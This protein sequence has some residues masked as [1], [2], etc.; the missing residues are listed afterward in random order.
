MKHK[1][2][3][4]LPAIYIPVAA[5]LLITAF[6]LYKDINLGYTVLLIAS[7]AVIAVTA[8]IVIANKSVD[9]FVT[10]L[11]DALGSTQDNFITKS[12]L[13]V[14]VCR[15]DGEIIWHNETLGKYMEEGVSLISTDIA[16][17]FG[18]ELELEGDTYTSE[19]QIG[20]HK[21]TLYGVCGGEDF[22]NLWNFYLVDNTKL[23]ND[24]FEFHES[25]PVML[26]MVVDSYDEMTQSSKE[27]E[28]SQ[29]LGQIEYHIEE[30]IGKRDGFV[31]KL[32]RELYAAVVEERHIREIIEN[33][34][35]ILDNVRDVSGG[36]RAPITLSIG[37]GRGGANFA[38][39]E[40][41][42]RQSLDMALGRGGDQAAVKTLSGYDFYGG[43]S[44][45][46]ERRTKVKTRIVANAMS[47]L[48]EAADNVIVMGHKFADLDS[49][50]AAVGVMKIVSNMGKPVHCAIDRAKCLVEPFI[51]RL[52]ADGYQGMFIHPSN[53]VNTVTAH[54][55][56]IIVDTHLIHVVESEE[57]YRACKN[58]VVIDHHRRMVGYI[59]N[60]IIFYHEPYA[61]SAAEMV[62]ELSQ[63][64][65]EKNR[66]GRSE[67]EALLSGIMLDTKN[68]IIKTGVRTFEAAA[69][70]RKMGA[71][72]VEVRKLFSSSMEAYQTRSRLVSEA[73]I[74][75]RCAI[76]LNTTTVEDIRV[77]APQAADELLTISD[78]DASFVM[79]ETKEGISLSARSMGKLN[80]QVIAETLGG[81]GHQTMSGAQLENVS[82][83]TARQLLLEAIDKY[84]AESV[85]T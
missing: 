29:L 6:V 4:F 56:L 23:K 45:G 83:E 10:Q 39:A 72:T 74:Y 43:V 16:S 18:E 76:S 37:V 49:F 26:L 52:E 9:N 51:N 54:T 60:A 67:A 24:A 19:V 53:L 68:F 65:G 41:F 82:I 1:A 85:R 17:L 62:T 13:P 11:G 61:S 75:K 27:N 8:N 30:F 64:F 69:Y 22:Q 73:E 38:E 44:K 32:E 34:F 5:L 81:G 57:L 84:F 40:S 42:A 48:I 21:F 20:N 55:L 77:V 36:D 66:I 31:V 7:M 14:I 80:V 12:S 58:V 28:R 2:K 47:E 3:L 35:K 33:R 79:Y 70:L 25:R 15:P 63:Y 50:G 78:V 59:D 46:V 71:D